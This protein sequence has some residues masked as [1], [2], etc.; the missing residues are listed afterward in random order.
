MK[1]CHHVVFSKMVIDWA[2]WSHNQLELQIGAPQLPPSIEKSRRITR[3]QTRGGDSKSI[4]MLGVVAKLLSA[5]DRC[6]CNC[7][8]YE[9]QSSCSIS[10]AFFL[11]TYKSV[12]TN[13]IYS[14]MPDLG[15]VRGIISEQNP[16]SDPIQEMLVTIKGLQAIF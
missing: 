16:G 3:Q 15:L 6:M 1:L 5:K 4:P 8:Y 12:R 10:I 14:P 7:I 13:S 9:T 11:V 2:K